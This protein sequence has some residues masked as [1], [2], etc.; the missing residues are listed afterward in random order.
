M[1]MSNVN[2]WFY[3]YLHGEVLK[4][5]SGVD[6]C[7]EVEED[8]TSEVFCADGIV[9]HGKYMDESLIALLL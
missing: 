4:R 9:T 6:N 2:N 1:S 7:V 8:T 3:W 5:L